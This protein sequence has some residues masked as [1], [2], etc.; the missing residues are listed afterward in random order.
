MKELSIAISGENNTGKSTV[1]VVL[2]QKMAELGYQVSVPD[3]VV[4]LN[5]NESALSPSTCQETHLTF[6]EHHRGSAREW[7]TCNTSGTCLGC[8]VEATIK[9]EFG[10]QGRSFLQRHLNRGVA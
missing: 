10:T 8:L 9:R 7:C 6:V 2:A 3:H 1:L 4:G 5:V